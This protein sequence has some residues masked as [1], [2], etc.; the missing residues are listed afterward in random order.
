M[1]L[2]YGRA[3]CITAENGGFRPGQME[4]VQSHPLF[5]SDERKAD[6]L[7]TVGD[8]LVPRVHR[9]S[10]PF[11]LAIEE[12][13]DSRLGGQYIE[14][15]AATCSSWAKLLDKKYPLTGQWQGQ[16]PPHEVEHN[17][18]VYGAGPSRKQSDARQKK[19]DSGQAVERPMAIRTAGLLKFIRNVAVA[20]MIQMVET[21]QSSHR[22]QS[23]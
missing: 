5:W 9:S 1:A 12:A 14:T 7:A 17:Y 4:A 8:V 11:L 21:G 13:A 22:R 19:L 3:G 10:S 18:H 23:H 6:Y 16:L 20:H 15:E 2:L